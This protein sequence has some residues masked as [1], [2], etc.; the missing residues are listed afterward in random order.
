MRRRLY[1]ETERYTHEA[2]DIS[3]AVYSAVEPIVR[4]AA[5]SGVSIR[6]LGQVVDGTVMEMIL[7]LFFGFTATEDPSA[8]QS[9]PQT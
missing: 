8:D 9:N 2:E 7:D 5:L 4:A 6:D 1:D 3:S